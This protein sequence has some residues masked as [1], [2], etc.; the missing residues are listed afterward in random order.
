V[1]AGAL[2]GAGCSIDIRAGD[3][4]VTEE[5]RFTAGP[6]PQ[7]SLR[8]FDGS[9]E[10]RS[11]DGN[12]VVVQIERRA[13]TEEEARALE[14]RATEEGGRIV[15]EAVSPRDGRPGVNIAGSS[16]AVSL[17]VRTPRRISLEAVTGDGSIAA[18]D[19]EGTMT[20]RTGDGS[21]RLDGVD[22][23]TTAHS[24]DGSIA[25]DR[26]S[27]ELDLESGDG[28]ITVSG[29]LG[30]LRVSTGDGSISIH[31]EDGSRMTG[32]WTITTGDGSVSVDLPPAFD[33]DVDARGER[34][35]DTYQR[36]LGK[37]GRTLQVRSG[38]G[39]IDVSQR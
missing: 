6:D 23:R 34:E 3:A 31:V 30:M 38:D 24:G 21:I 5:K 12:E 37:G 27:G 19:L 16:P 1:I 25:V 9:I 17:V 8:T 7:L 35:D 26:A 20:L 15:V 13:A 36:Q 32:D 10:V 28:S 11:A 39:S 4:M 29:R 33:A 14:V 22:G 18:A 2:G